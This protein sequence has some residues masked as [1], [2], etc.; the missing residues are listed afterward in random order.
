MDGDAA[1]GASQELTG[2]IGIAAIQDLP[3]A[4]PPQ[5][6]AANALLPVRNASGGIDPRDRVG[7]AVSSRAVGRAPYSAS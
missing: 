6:L 1:P 3:T 7:S 2:V 4:D 5:S